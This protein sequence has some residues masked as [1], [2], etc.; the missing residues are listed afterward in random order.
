[1]K[2]VVYHSDLWRDLVEQGWITAHIYRVDG[3]RWAVML[4]VDERRIA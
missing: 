3:V 4:R 2:R 1:V